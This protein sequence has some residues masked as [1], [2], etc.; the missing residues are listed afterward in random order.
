[1]QKC[2][3]YVQKPLGDL[4]CAFQERGINSPFWGGA[5]LALLTA[6][7]IPNTISPHS[8][9]TVQLRMEIM[10]SKFSCGS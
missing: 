1:M 3:I 6:E 2:Y 10:E 8:L 5:W 4:R 9:I 7:S